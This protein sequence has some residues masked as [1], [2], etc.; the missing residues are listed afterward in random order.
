VTNI[1]TSS[2][3]SISA[4]M[5]DLLTQIDQE[6]RSAFLLGHALNDSLDKEMGF[7][8]RICPIV[9]HFEEKLS[10]SSIKNK[11][12]LGSH[13]GDYLTDAYIAALAAYN[14]FLQY[15]EHLGR[16]NNAEVTYRLNFTQRILLSALLLNLSFVR[17]MFGTPEV[18]FGLGSVETENC[19]KIF[20]LFF[21]NLTKARNAFVHKGERDAEN[22]HQE[23]YQL[24]S[25]V[26]GFKTQLNEKIDISLSH[27]LIDGFVKDLCLHFNVE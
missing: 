18:K 13:L 9:K 20:D 4:D 10:V 7:R 24:G 26:Y 15:K 21:P 5:D 3:D 17:K 2:E 1:D 25:H 22:L 6:E 12:N 11:L 16:G 27:F 14:C 8:R 23:I 19:L